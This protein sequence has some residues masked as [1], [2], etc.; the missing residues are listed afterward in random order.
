MPAARAEARYGPTAGCRTGGS[1]TTRTDARRPCPAAP[2]QHRERRA[3]IAGAQLAEV[4]LPDP[5][6][7]RHVSHPA[8][9]RRFARNRH[10]AH[11]FLRPGTAI[12]GG[13][14]F[15]SAWP[16]G[17]FARIISR[18]SEERYTFPRPSN[19][20]HLP[21]YA[22]VGHD[23]L[24]VDGRGWGVGDVCAAIAWTRAHGA[25]QIRA[26]QVGQRAMATW[27]QIEHAPI[28]ALTGDQSSVTTRP[29]ASDAARSAG[30]SRR[31]GCR[32]RD[33]GVLPVRPSPLIRYGQLNGSARW[34]RL[35]GD[36]A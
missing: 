24:P 17:K 13:V 34:P 31:R 15:V 20:Q 32:P 22:L 23:G 11:V 4:R 16:P 27:T 36:R 8:D 28:W 33:R 10:T 29:E 2:A 25:E 21:P 3:G 7:V 14:F 6:S 19:H 5:I 26:W 18:K 1:P 12:G 35:S 30:N 9:P